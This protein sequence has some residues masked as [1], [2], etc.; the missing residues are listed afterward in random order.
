VYGA[1]T[2]FGRTGPFSHLAG[3]EGVVMAKMGAF[4]QLRLTPAIRPSFAATPSA[5]FSAAQTLIQG[6]M[7]TFVVF[8]SRAIGW[9]V[10]RALSRSER[11]QG[12]GIGYYV[13]TVVLDLVLGLL[14]AII[15]G[16]VHQFDQV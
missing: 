5:S 3:Y 14:A 12:P 9:F 1:V 11:D 10:D 6:V 16:W 7:N 13:T 8:L 15:A 2:G 4:G